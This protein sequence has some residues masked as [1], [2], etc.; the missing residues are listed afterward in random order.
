[1]SEPTPPAP[2]RFRPG[3]PHWLALAVSVLPLAL[4][5]FSSREG[6]LPLYFNTARAFLDGAVPN[7]DFRFEYP[8]YA[9]LWFVPATW[10][11]GDVRGFILAFGLQLTLFD[12]LIK[13]L[14]LSEGARRWGTGWRAWVPFAAYSV[15]SWIQSLH[16]LKR[17]DLLPAA[18]TLFALVAL[19]RRR[20]GWAGVA[21]AVGA[22]TKLYPAVLVPLALAV[23]WRRG[24]K[25][26]RALVAGLAAG[27]LP[28]VPL[29]FVWPWW[30]FA[31][32]HV[33]RG[34]QVESLSAGLLWAAHL[35][36]FAHAQWVHAPAAYELQGPD[37]EAV[38]AVTRQLWVAGSLLAAAVSVRGAWRRPP[39]HMEDLARLAG[40]PLVAFVILNPVL[41]PQ[42]LIWLTGAAA[43]ALLSGSVGPAA[44][45]LVAAAITRGIFAGS[46]YRTGIQPSFT[47]LL[48][49][50][51]AMVLGAGIAW[52]RE[53][54]RLGWPGVEALPEAKDA[55]SPTLS[56]G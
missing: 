29:S 36:G 37:A 47:L 55:P 45:L 8:P 16:Y 14:L 35:L 7:R 43:L 32:F 4:Y 34:L 21:L 49:A 44:A 6:D 28:L 22:V 25:P 18:L 19:M 51:N 27:V 30:K 12:A 48:L 23:C 17:Y 52:A 42:Y 3:P 20:E 56:G 10:V 54:W 41:S 38:R 31:S 40:V 50:R 13:W 11:G 39:V 1:M 53:A 9:L 15:V 33:E 46:T 24:A 5:A 2:F 26:T